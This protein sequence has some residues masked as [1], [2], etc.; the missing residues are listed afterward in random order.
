MMQLYVPS[1][2]PQREIAEREL[3]VLWVRFT[4]LQRMRREILADFGC[5]DA[6]DQN[7]LSIPE[8]DETVIAPIAGELRQLAC[9]AAKITAT[10]REDLEYKAIMLSEFLGPDDDSIQTILAT[11]LVMDIRRGHHDH[12]PD[13]ASAIFGGH[14]H[15][16][17]R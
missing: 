5:D 12:Q 8:L 1:S 4:K 3:E 13:H 16:H 7:A 14:A 9:C 17:W 10:C 15:A 6:P 2:A 11:S